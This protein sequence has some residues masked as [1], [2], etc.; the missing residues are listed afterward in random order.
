MQAAEN[1]YLVFWSG[2][3]SWWEMPLAMQAA[4]HD[5]SCG[6]AFGSASCLATILAA[7]RCLWQYDALASYE[8]LPWHCWSGGHV[9][10]VQAVLRKPPW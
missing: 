2:A 6:D 7:G 5:L 9:R 10:I 8:C 4:G 1:S 3:A